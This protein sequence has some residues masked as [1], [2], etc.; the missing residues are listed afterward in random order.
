MLGHSAIADAAIADVGGNLIVATAEMSAI[1]S[2]ATVAVGT[3]VGK[4]DISGI[5]TQTVEVSTKISGNIEL[6]SN[7]TTTPQNIALVKETI[8]SLDGNFVQTA[9]GNFTTAGSSSQQINFTKTVSGD[10]LY[11]AVVT[12]VATET[13]TEITPSGTETW[14][15]ITPSGTETWTEI[16]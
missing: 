6:S 11:T 14:T 5:F 16:Q 1:G 4:I 10:I 13:F 2:S 7:F 3:L 8:A 9:Q 12:D 15:E